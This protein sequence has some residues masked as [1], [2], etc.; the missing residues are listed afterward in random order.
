M[1]DFST[2][3]EIAR[4]SLKRLALDRVAPTPDNY[5]AYYH[6]IAGTKDD[7]CFPEQAFRRIAAEL[8]R[9]S[10]AQQR[11]AQRFESAIGNQSWPPLRAAMIELAE[12]TDAQEMPW[13]PLIQQI[14]EQMDRHHAAFTKARK[15]ESLKHVLDASGA[16]AG[17]LHTRLGNLLKHW[18]TAAGSEVAESFA[19]VADT[20]A[21][22]PIAPAT[23]AAAP[24][25]A[26]EVPPELAKALDELFTRGVG[27]LLA[28]AP[29]LQARIASF[30]NRLNPWPTRDAQPQL[31]ADLHE[32]ILKLEWTG[33]DQSGIRRALVALLQLLIDNISKLVID[34]Q[35]LTGQLSVVSEAFSQPLDIRILDEVERRL[36][37]VIDQQ[38]RIK[39]ELTD[40][41][42]R[43]K[44]MLAGFV[45][46]LADMS[47]SAGSFH[48][49]LERSS[50]RIAQAK[51]ISELSN[52]IED[53][54]R[55]T[56]VVQEGARRSRDDLASLQEKVEQANVEISKLQHELHHTSEL[57][58][59][60]PLTGA[61]NRKGLDEAL[62]R[63]IAR[64]R[65]RD[66]PL[67][68]GLL[69]VDNFKRINDT[70]G[71]HAG[72]AALQHLA[73]V[74]R[75]NLRPQDSLGR[76]GGEEFIVVLPDTDVEHA[77]AAI[78]RL[79]RAL[80]TRYF[81]AEGQKLLI[82]FSAGVAR[83]EADE[84]AA[85]AIDRADK[86]MYRAKRAGKNRVMLA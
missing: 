58:R 3:S 72:D 50:A 75:A 19:P 77:V 15:K 46:R 4:E 36:R 76:Y 33:E 9:R 70:H 78:T 39:Q 85:V 68:V 8:P 51:D 20:P 80:T 66:T 82:T 43:L 32:L 40:A 59:H 17:V 71:H 14:V 69:D 28:D 52:V 34:D 62:E 55:E 48:D 61:L 49:N 2:P 22:A 57:V 5:R 10:P 37:D 56:R 21:A 38:G 84:A 65:R 83:L 60:D 45:D 44:Q 25:P 6:R 74:I 35:W 29:D 73:D 81:L 13:A 24:L 23:T 67:C 18:S 7:D 31:L 11:F 79:Q 16:G 26:V 41:Q 54:L 30:G 42:L 47:E 86:A 64:A 12:A 1:A 53:M 63:E 27:A